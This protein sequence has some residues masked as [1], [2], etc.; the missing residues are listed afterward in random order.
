MLDAM[1]AGCRG[2]RGVA[3]A[4]LLLAVGLVACNDD[5]PKEPTTNC[6]GNPNPLR[7]RTVKDQ[8]DCV[9]VALAAQYGEPDPMIFKAQAD[10]ESGFNQFAVSPDT[11]C[12]SGH[13]DWT[14]DEKKSFGLMQ[15]TPAC[16]WAPQSILPDGHPNLTRDP[17]SDLWA[18]S[19]F[20]PTL[21]L[22]EGVRA[23]SVNRSELA[24]AYPGCTESQYTLMAIGAFNAGSSTIHGCNSMD[25]QP[26]GYVSRVLDKY[27][28][29]AGLA[30]YAYRY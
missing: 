28:A 29:F 26:T 25:A 20:N 30:G 8:F 12:P 14:V 11:P 2:K 7:T 15:L 18:T 17:S 3:S 21:N 19:I 22:G 23:V 6:D 1:F 24:G 16:G 27:K 4:I 10:L 5:L 13:T 9:F